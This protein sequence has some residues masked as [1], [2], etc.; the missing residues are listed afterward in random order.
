[1]LRSI[2]AFALIFVSTEAL[3]TPKVGDAASFE[4]AV[5]QNGQSAIGLVSI[6][7]MSYDAARGF[8]QRQTAEFPGSAPEVT[9]EW[10]PENEFFSD[11]T[12]DQ[13]LGKGNSSIGNCAH[14]NGTLQAIT[15]PAGTFDSC[16]IPFESAENKGTV[17]VAKVSLGIVR[18]DLVSK[19]NGPSMSSMLKSFR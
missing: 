15:V 10:M 9:E 2:F 8:L 18:L 6:E 17:W 13:L 11:A 7:L 1:M 5:T 3:A 19:Q 4:T 14:F 16:A 12:I